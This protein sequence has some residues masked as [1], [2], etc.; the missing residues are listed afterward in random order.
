MKED[1]D[2]TGNEFNYFTTFWTIGYTIG[3]IPSQYIITYVR[4][5][6]YLPACEVGWAITTFSFAAVKTS[7]QVYAMRFLIGLIESPFYI[8][9]MTLLGNWYTPKELAKRAGIFYSASFAANM[10]SG[11]LQAGVYKGM[12]GLHGLAGWR[13]LFIMCGIIT[14]P[15][16]FY[17]FFAVPDSPFNTRAR[18][19]TEEERELARSRMTRIG[20]KP[21]SGATWATF[22]SMAKRPFVWLFVVNY[23]FFCL[24]TYP[25][26]FFAIYLKALKTYSVSKVNVSVSLS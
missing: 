26:A 10:F 7:K 25:L 20:R 15:G 24:D 19:L 4:P 5:S 23:I 8:G 11:Y 3:M 17:G 22:K 21:F 1:L 18:Y 14:V 9:A 16:A 6:Y 12:N 2:I 13:W